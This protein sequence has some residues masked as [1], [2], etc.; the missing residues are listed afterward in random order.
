MFRTL[1]GSWLFVVA[2]CV[3]AVDATLSAAPPSES[4]DPDRQARVD[5]ST[6]DQLDDSTKRTLTAAVSRVNKRLEQE[7]GVLDPTPLAVS[8]VR[9]A[10]E[11]TITKVA[12]SD[13][14]D[15]FAIVETLQGILSSGR[16]PENVDFHLLPGSMKFEKGPEL[17]QKVISLNY[18]LI[19]QTPKAKADKQVLGLTNLYEAFRVIKVE[20]NK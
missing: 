9:Q 4:V 1:V 19:V 11:F 13:M 20:T 6:A 7:Y 16:L 14:P 18:G 2:L 5:S 8:R 15:R 3:L 12:E 17:G 10:I